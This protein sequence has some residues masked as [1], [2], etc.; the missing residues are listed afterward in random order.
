MPT[1]T[2][3][4]ALSSLFRS[5]RRCSMSGIRPPGLACRCDAATRAPSTRAPITVSPSFAMADYPTGSAVL[6]CLRCARHPG[7]VDGHRL[8][9]RLL[10]K[11]TDLLLQLVDL[12]LRRRQGRVG[13]RCLRRLVIVITV[14]VLHL[15]LEDSHGPAERPG[16]VRHL[17]AAE[18]YDQHRRDDEHLPWAVK[19]VTEHVQ[20]LPVQVARLPRPVRRQA[21]GCPASGTR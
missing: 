4:M 10:L 2:A 9:R 1:S 8:A 11:V 16:R 5:S 7:T 18:K 14:Q 17:P 19:Q 15:G 13:P 12:L 6:L 3:V 21:R 20:S